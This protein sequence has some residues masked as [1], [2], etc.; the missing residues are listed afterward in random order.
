[1][2]KSTLAILGSP[3]AYDTN[4]KKDR[5]GDEDNVDALKKNPTT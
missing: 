1:M 2:E 5:F 3:Q 4:R